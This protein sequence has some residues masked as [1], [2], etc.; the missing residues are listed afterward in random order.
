MHRILLAAFAALA[1]V[2]ACK[3]TTLETT[4]VTKP[5]SVAP[6]APQRPHTHQEHGVVRDDP[7]HWMRD[8][9]D[10]EL[11][12]YL[13]AENQWTSQ[14][15]AH[16]AGLR[17]TLFDEMLGRIQ[18]DDDTVPTYRDGWWYYARTEAGKPYR[19]YCRK[20]GTLDAPEQIILDVNVLGEGKDYID[21][22]GIAVSPDHTRLTYAIDDTGREQYDLHIRD[23]ATGTDLPDVIEDIWPNV[24]WSTDNRT[25]LYTRLDDAL[26]PY[27]VVRHT[28]GGTEQAVVYE[29]TDPKF[30]VY[31]DRSSDDRYLFVGSNSSTTDEVRYLPADQPSAT[32]AVFTPRHPG[33]EYSVDSQDDRFL[34]LT[35]DHDDDAGRH[36]DDAINFQVKTAQPGATDRSQWTPLVPHR[37]NVTV[38]DV[39]AFATHAVVTEREDGLT[40]FRVIDRK[41]GAQHRIPMPEA[42]FVVGAG[43]NP[44]YDA[45]HFRF[46][47]T[48]LTTP[49]TTYDY[50]LP[51][52][53]LTVKK[54]QPVLGGYV[55]EAYVA[56]RLMATAPDGTR[57]PISLVRRRAVPVDG[58]AP[59]LLYGYG[60]Y[61]ITID[62]QF[63]AAR[64]SLLDRGV[65]FAIAH[66]RGG[67][68]LGRTW[69]EDGKF[70][71]KENTFT[72]FI[73]AGEH[74]VAQGYTTHERMAIQGGS[75]GGLLIGAVINQAPKL[76][77]HAV[78]QV[79][80]VDV[81]STMLD[82]SIPLTANEWEE[83]GDPRERFWFGVMLKYS[84]YDNVRNGPYPN[85]L[86]TS[87]LNDPRVQYWEPTKWVAR[88]RDRTTN[89]S[90]LLL[91]MEMGT[92]H[93]GKSGRYGY[94]DD[95]AFV[96]AWLLDK[97]GLA[98]TE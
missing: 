66:V 10:P 55:K 33:H 54:V 23:L 26:R 86:V 70:E 20:Q 88:L 77:A 32:P 17:K 73:A 30:R 15:T 96:Y 91:K 74:L 27:Q 78:A 35:N 49:S 24:T 53:T 43:D 46:T 22:S 60:A 71:K 59:L 65:I 31:V 63:S 85:L 89:R 4:A 98:P 56:E 95:V 41:T 9:E 82:E 2:G 93:G 52:Q 1:A 90:Q 8:K 58:K 13:H 94:L 5:L 6:D 19:I 28:L 81:V 68:F 67:G 11:L 75:A 50:D 38:Q 51:T 34:I 39:S 97:W 61:G 18:E 57:I 12:A 72:D 25:V 83:W 3:S 42:V 48:S 79:P 40:W 16:L 44:S 87:G 62:P 64:L 69:K 36:D 47:Y 45:T 80:F 14:Q 29:E 76:A 21:V 37:A 92:G 84:P 7:Y